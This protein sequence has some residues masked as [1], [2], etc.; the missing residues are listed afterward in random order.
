MPVATQEDWER[1]IREVLGFFVVEWNNRN[2]EVACDAYALDASYV[3]KD[4]HFRGRPEIIQRY[5][6]AYP[7]PAA[8]GTL[9]IELLEHRVAP[10]EDPHMATA[11]LRWTIVRG[12]EK[13]SG[14]AMETYELQNR[15]VL[16][17]QDVTVE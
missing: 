16:I 5:R 15:R 14:F 6:R 12:Q 13:F 7:D 3:G 17:V 11:I 2:L 8:M 1:M 10:G 4:G 9:R